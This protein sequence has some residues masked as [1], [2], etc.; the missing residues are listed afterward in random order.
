MFAI[1]SLITVVL[2]SA[3]VGLFVMYRQ[4]FISYPTIKIGQHG[5]RRQFSIIIAARNEAQHIG[6]CIQSILNNDYDLD[7]IE[8]LVMNDGSTDSTKLIATQFPHVRVIDVPDPPAT[9][10][11]AYK[12][13]AIHNG[14]LESQ[15]DTIICIDADVLVQRHWLSSY[16]SYY[17]RLKPQLILGPVIYRDMEGMLSQFQLIDFATMQGITIAVNGLNWGRM[18]NGANLSFLK[19]AYIDVDGFDGSWHQASGD[20]YTLIQ[21]F[22]K[23]NYD[24]WFLKHPEA[25]VLTFPQPNWR[26]FL[27]QRIRWASKS[28]KNDDHRIT[29]TLV[30]VYLLNVSLMALLIYGLV[31]GDWMFLVFYAC[32]TFIK[33]FIEAYFTHHVFAFYGLFYKKLR[34]LLFQ[35]IHQLYICVAGFMGW[36]GHFEWKQRKI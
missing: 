30:L 19:E 32:M 28:G 1:L 16:N 9:D 14:V 13:W 17:E 5:R 12:K 24:V 21:K 15:Y 7:A 22:S 18:G 25:I 10:F 2:V 33:F 20:D 34:L 35:P 11:K 36:F 31:K 3:Y 29:L 6:A 23:V 27:Q 4:A 26:A 8:I